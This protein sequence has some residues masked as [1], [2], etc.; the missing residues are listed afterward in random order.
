MSP[1]VIAIVLILAA[2]FTL[3]SLTS[4]LADASD[5]DDIGL[6]AAQENDPAPIKLS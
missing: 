4:I 6:F 1:Y 5:G 2:L 3:L